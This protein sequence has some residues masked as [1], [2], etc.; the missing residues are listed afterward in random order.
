MQCDG[1]HFDWF[2]I[3]GQWHFLHQSALKETKESQSDIVDANDCARAQG[4]VR[5][6]GSPRMATLVVTLTTVQ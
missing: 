3:F 6:R 4:L 1:R 2:V 5:V